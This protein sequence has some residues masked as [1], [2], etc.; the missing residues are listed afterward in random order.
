MSM[1]IPIDV[2]NTL[3]E[4][5]GKEDAEK[6]AKA[7]ESSISLIEE[8]GRSIA[9]QLKL[10]AKDELRREM[11]DE[12]ATKEDIA[13]L[14]GELK[15]DI[16]VLRGEMRSEIARLEKKFTV[17]WLI[18]LFVIIFLNQNSIETLARLFGLLK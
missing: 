1:S 7:I 9:K 18:T 17:Q 5:L 6:V 2:Y 8:R 3:I 16:A 10:E 12:L 11:R 13:N 15:E 4:R 14:R